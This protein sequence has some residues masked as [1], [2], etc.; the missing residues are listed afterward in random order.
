V[1]VAAI[2][3]GQEGGSYVAPSVAA[4][5]DAAS[6]EVVVKLDLFGVLVLAVATGTVAVIV[7]V[8][9]LVV[10]ALGIWVQR[11]SRAGGVIASRRRRR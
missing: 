4:G 11:R 2:G 5:Y 6:R 7:V 3:L 9:V 10:L 8:V 1:D